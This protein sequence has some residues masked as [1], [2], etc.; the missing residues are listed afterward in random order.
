MSFESRLA[1]PVRRNE[2]TNKATSTKRRR[3]FSL[4]L[5]LRRRRGQF[6]IK[7]FSD[8]QNAPKLSLTRRREA[9]SFR[10][11]ANSRMDRRRATGGV[12]RVIGEGWN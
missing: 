10:A 2:G 3:S 1:E 11:R 6:E 4:R 9:A 5:R 12:R 8:T 7:S